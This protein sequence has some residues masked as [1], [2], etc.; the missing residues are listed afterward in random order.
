MPPEGAGAPG[1]VTS[2]KVE[3]EL[4]QYARD[5]FCRAGDQVKDWPSFWAGYRA[6]CSR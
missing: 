6:A 5:A 2:A 4:K 1:E 3:E